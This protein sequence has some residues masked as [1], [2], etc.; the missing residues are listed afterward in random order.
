MY[1]MES[2]R[3]YFEKKF[4]DSVHSFVTRA[5]SLGVTKEVETQLLYIETLAIGGKR[6]RPYAV[7]AAY[8]AQDGTQNIFDVLCAIELLHVFALVH[9]DIMDNAHTRHGVDTAHLFARDIYAAKKDSYASH[10]GISQGILIGDLIFTWSMES[11]MRGVASFDTEKRIHA[12]KIYTTLLEEVTVGQMIDVD[13]SA[14]TKSTVVDVLQKNRLKSGNYTFVRPIL[15]GSVLGGVVEKDIAAI[16]KASGYLGEA[17]QAQDDLL[18]IFGEDTGKGLCT[19]VA[20]GQHTLVSAYMSEQSVDI[21]APFFEK[22]NSTIGAD[23]IARIQGL[24][25]STGI[26]KSIEEIIDTAFAE[27]HTCI[28]ELPKKQKAFFEEMIA[29]LEKRKK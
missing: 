2:F 20:S 26:K 12:Q 29:I 23:D 10:R 11:F 8:Q 4:I 22:R 18:D 5:I 27:V 1:A 14:N 15:L 7:Y 21:A 25:E 13:I 6:F 24:I 3:G 16:E 17:F 9:D 28:H 19:D